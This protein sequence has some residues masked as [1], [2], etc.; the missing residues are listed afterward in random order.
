MH[1][2]HCLLSLYVCLSSGCLLSVPPLSVPLVQST[3]P[4]STN[5]AFL[6]Q[7]RI[8][9]LYVSIVVGTPSQPSLCF[10]S[11]P[12]LFPSRCGQELD[13]RPQSP[14]IDRLSDCLPIHRVLRFSFCHIINILHRDT[15]AQPRRH[16]YQPQP[17]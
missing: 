3:K 13:S 1:E 4:P 11:P 2:C 15:N 17:S 7:H 12:I 6:L 16:H 9:Q 10:V 5:P 8:S 14:S